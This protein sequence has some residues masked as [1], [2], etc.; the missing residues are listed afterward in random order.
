MDDEVEDAGQ[1]GIA[2]G[3]LQHLIDAAPEGIAVV[4]AAADRYEYVN[5]AGR[6]LLGTSVEDAVGGPSVFPA[7]VDGAPPGEP[8]T[9]EL[10]L[11]NRVLQHVTTTA[12]VDGR[13]LRMVHFRDVSRD[14]EHERHL[15]AF[16][17][18]SAGIA[19]AGPLPTV[20]DRLAAE[21]QRATGMLSCTF[22]LMD[23]DGRLRRTGTVDGAYPIC[24][25]YAE[26][27]EQCRALGA[28]LLSESAFRDRRPVLAH[29]WRRR[30]LADPRFAPLHDIAR[31]ASWSTLATVPVISRGEPIGVLNGFYLAGAEPTRGDIPFLSAIA[32]QAAVAVENAR[33]VGE[34]ESRAAVEE[35]HL[36]ARELHDS[37]NQALFSLELQVGAL[38]LGL[39]DGAQPE[40]L[41]QRITQIRELTESAHSEMR[42]MLSALRPAG[43]R[44]GG[45]VH[46]LR[47]HAAEVSARVGLEITVDAADELALTP[48]VEEQLFW[49][50]REAL[51]NVVKHADAGSVRVCVDA[52][53]DRPPGVRVTV[54][55]DG[56][57]FDPASAQP[58]HLGFESMAERMAQVGGTLEVTS[59]SGG[60]VVCARAPGLLRGQAA[61]AGT[62]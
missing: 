50:V 4:D 53:P 55:D 40:F 17:R 37:V 36:L 38:E 47:A 20:L 49:V 23:D 35:R 42:A 34:L 27:L 51:H 24:P 6:R 10:V 44:D 31:D 61:T 5:P 46:A 1:A 59:R 14:R 41:A 18:I 58:G 2:R 3:A 13:S 29:G 25:D 15:A 9:A 32:D 30:V 48:V 26:R 45:L 52:D 8:V 62:R 54:T 22:M 16:R 39:Q 56:K 60:T 12:R 33:L 7:P 43:L 21:V 11:G 57:G 19:F 28:P